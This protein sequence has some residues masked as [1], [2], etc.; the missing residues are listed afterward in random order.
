[1]RDIT[2][3][4]SSIA[5]VQRYLRELHH[6]TN[7]DIPLVNPDGIYGEETV[8]AVEAFQ[9]ANGLAV[10]GRVDNATWDAIYEAF[11]EAL[12][13]RAKP[14]GI[15]PFPDEN[16]Y[17]VVEGESSDVVMAVQ[18]VLRLLANIYDDIGG[19]NTGGVYDEPTAADVRAF[20]ARHNLPVTGKVD[21]A[22]WNAL[23]GAYNRAMGVDV[24]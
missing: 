15:S 10:T 17:E 12:T 20:Q 23:A 24:G 1:M 21:K 11:L 19:T 22:T 9:R 14:V 8:A 16:G 18:L 5:E 6:D 7:G 13:R 3:D 4:K 2:N